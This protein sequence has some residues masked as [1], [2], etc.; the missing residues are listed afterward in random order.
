VLASAIDPGLV[1]ALDG[2]LGAGKTVFVKGL[3]E[4]LGV[5]GDLVSSPTFVIAQRYEG[6]ALRL[7]HVDLYRIEDEDELQGFGFD[8]MLDPPDIAAIEWSSRFPD[9]LPADRLRISIARVGRGAN[10]AHRAGVGDAALR[11]DD[12]GADARRIEV[13]ASGPVSN[14]AMTSWTLALEH[15]GPIEQAARDGA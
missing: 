11:R 5:D 10:G 8:E 7:H 3:A 13:E 6:R 15:G 9:A 14:E 4:G 1:I 2:D 12:T